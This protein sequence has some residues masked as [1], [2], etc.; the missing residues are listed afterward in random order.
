MS[1]FLYS[2]IMQ[3]I[4]LS[5]L[6]KLAFFSPIQ[7]IFLNTSYVTGCILG[8]KNITVLEGPYSHS[9]CFLFVCFVFLILQSS[10]L[11]ALKPVGC[12]LYNIDMFIVE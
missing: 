1:Q 5:L 2:L 7:Q 11:H 8:T 3:V 9:S 6:K 4:V 10:L 12:F